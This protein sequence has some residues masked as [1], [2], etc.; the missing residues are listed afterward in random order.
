M[1]HLLFILLLT[2]LIACSGSSPNGAKPAATHYLTFQFSSKP[3]ALNISDPGNWCAANFGEAA[4]IS[5]DPKNIFHKMITLSDIPTKV[6]VDYGHLSAAFMLSKVGDHVE[7]LTSDNLPA[8]LSNKNNF[9]IYPEGTSFRYDN[10][11]EIKF[12][13]HLEEL[14]NGL[15]IS[16]DLPL[17]GGHGI[18]A[19]RCPT[20]K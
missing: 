12:D 2:S 11:R 19:V 17:N 6:V 18:A 13:V 3:S 4:M 15:Q 8:C 16:I 7:I 5:A 20:C 1:K 9:Q 10:K 14:P